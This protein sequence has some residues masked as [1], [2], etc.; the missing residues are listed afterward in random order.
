MIEEPREHSLCVYRLG[1]L[2]YQSAYR[3]QERLLEARTR[4]QIPDT[5]LLLEHDPVITL[6]RGAK[7]SHLLA[8]R[9]RLAK[10]GIDVFETDRGGDVTYHGPGQLVAY[11][12]IDLGAA[13]RDVRRYVWKLEEVMIRTAAH[14]GLAAQRVPGFHGAWIGEGK[15]GAVGVRICRW[16]TMH[17]F[18]LNVNTDLTAFDLIVPCGIRGRQVTS[19]ARELG[20]PVVMD[21][22]VDTT[23][24]T[25]AEVFQ[26]TPTAA[27]FLKI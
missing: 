19:L 27:D 16:V 1:R 4:H 6:G 24:L 3:L 15:I 12:V 2:G 17:G 11:P 26:K 20:R 14:F 10:N 21:D 22:V 13:E 25:F 18:A 8:D 5:L 9:Q 7:E 23:A